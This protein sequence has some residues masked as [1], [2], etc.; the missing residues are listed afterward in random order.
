MHVS[1]SVLSDIVV[2]NKYA[3]YIPSINRRE[4]WEEICDRN[5]NMH[6]KKFPDLTDT[7][8]SIY[9]KYVK[10]KKIL[11]SMRSM[12]FAGAPIEISNT[13]IFNCAYLP[14][15]HPFAFAETMFLLLSGTGVGYSVQHRHIDKL[16]VIVGPSTKTRRFLIGDSIEGW[17]D[18]IKVLVK[19]YTTGKSEPVFDFRDIRPKGARLVTS[20][21][22]APGPDP[23]R[24]CLTHIKAVLNDAIGRKLRSLEVHDIC[25]FIA[26]AVL[27]GGIRRAAMICGFDHDDFDMLSCKSGTWWELN[28]QR[29]RA[30][31]SVMLDRAVITHEQFKNIWDLIKQ[32]G[33]G[34]PGIYWTN[35]L[36]YYTNPCAEISLAPNSFCNLTEVNV[37]DVKTQ[38]ELNERVA[39][40]AIIGTIQ[41]SYTDFHYLRNIWKETTERD[42]LI[43][44]G[45]TGIASGA[46]LPLDLTAAAQVVMQSNAHYAAILGINPAAR[47]TTIKPSGSTSCVVG[48]A[49]GIHAWHDEYYIRRMRVGKNESLHKY[50]AAALPELLEDCRFKPHLESVLSIPQK[51][52]AGAIMRS[53]SAMELLERVKRF[54]IEWVKAGHRRGSNTNN[55]SCTISLMESDWVSVGEWM[56]SN[57]DSYNGISV[58]PYDGGTYVQAPFESC[59]REEYKS[60]V[61]KLHDIDLTNVIEI[62]DQTQLSENL[63]CSGGACE[64]Q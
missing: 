61:S 63:A 7:I 19:A 56:W 64:I 14:I 16:P 55:V 48:S 60:L 20:G 12:Q 52:P 17:A 49:S 10:T 44:V 57:R 39:A 24:I 8:T 22:K 41:A 27:A 4:T 37:S 21:G 31:N 43:G 9:N 2:F 29:G 30:N 40:A 11:P 42:A 23:L 47:S 54:N 59:T 25:C 35:D 28:P 34:E 45:M 13:R 53:E 51:A 15:D 50:I 36:E 58:L 1:Q 6:I 18:S 3:K 38:K 32:S 26:D 62:D 33:A 5:M 46:V